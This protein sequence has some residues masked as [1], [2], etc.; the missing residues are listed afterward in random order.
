MLVGVTGSCESCTIMFQTATGQEVQYF[1]MSTEG[2]VNTNVTETE[3][4]FR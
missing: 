1:L 4:E 3:L 2:R